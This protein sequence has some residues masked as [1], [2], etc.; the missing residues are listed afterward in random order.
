MKTENSICI[1][2]CG[3][4]TPIGTTAKMSGEM[5]SVNMTR[6]LTHPLYKDRDDNPIILSLASY[7]D[8]ANTVSERFKELLAYALPDVL[9]RINV[10]DPSVF[11]GVPEP[12]SGLTDNDIDDVRLFTREILENNNITS[13]DMQIL[14][15]GHCSALMGME[16]ACK[17][18]SQGRKFCIAGGIESYFAFETL[19][20]LSARNR[21]KT[22]SN[23]FGFTPGEA[24]G[25]VLLTTEKTAEQ[26][27]IPVLAELVAVSTCTEKHTIDKDTV[28]Q[29][30]GLSKAMAAVLQSLPEN[31]RIDHIF[32][33]LNGERYRTDEYGFAYLNNKKYFN[34]ASSVTAPAHLWGDIGAAAGPNLI[35]LAIMSGEK[36]SYNLIW[37]SSDS[38]KRSALLLKIT[39]EKNG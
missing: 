8:R 33:D 2:K 15:F 32:C 30:R 24:A 34:R 11:I 9:A 39:G 28:C 20:W 18:L 35:N 12:R 7:I 36:Q 23:K 22:R 17:E 31:S 10:Q 25:F 26:N 1:V 3:A 14:P 13:S 16:Q 5:A 4:S 38:G 37:T 6:L 21:L 19:T 27:N 29:G